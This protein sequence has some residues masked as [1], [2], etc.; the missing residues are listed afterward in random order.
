MPYKKG[1]PRHNEVA[2][3]SYH[4]IRKQVVA[5]LGDKCSWP[6]CEWTD[7]RVLQIDHI[8]GGGRQEYKKQ[9][10]ARSY[11]LKILRMEN[12]KIKYQ[13]LCANHNWIKRIENSENS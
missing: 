3:A 8:H 5:L 13:L 9:V 12:P 1:D 6:G 7:P 11:Y 2:K 10:N 4:R